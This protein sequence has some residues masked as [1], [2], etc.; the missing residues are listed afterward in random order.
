MVRVVRSTQGEIRIPELGVEITPGPACEG[1]ISNVEGILMRV[2]KILDGTLLNGDED[3]RRTASDLKQKIADT[4]NG[5]FAIT[6]IIE[7]PMGNSLI[8]SERAKKEF[9]EPVTENT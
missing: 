8:D 3:Q 7:D 5:C 2:D 9:F 4:K 1:F 6:L